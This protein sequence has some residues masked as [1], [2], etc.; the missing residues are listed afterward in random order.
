MDFRVSGKEK[1]ELITAATHLAELVKTMVVQDGERFP[2]L[3]DSLRA[4]LAL[5]HEPVEHWSPASGPAMRWGPMRDIAWIREL[6][7]AGGRVRI[8]RIAVRETLF[9]R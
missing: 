3:R 5:T 1:T 9:G 2:L 6:V 7:V 8:G 4:D